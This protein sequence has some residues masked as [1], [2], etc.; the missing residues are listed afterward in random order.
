T[1]VVD[2]VSA[3]DVGKFPDSDVGESLGRI[4]GVT[5]GRAFGQGA[6][7][8][9]RG[10]APQMTLT[11]LN[12]QNVASTGWYD[13]QAIDR[14]FNYS[15]LPSQ[16]VGGMEVYK[17]SQADLNEGG[18]G[19]IVIVKTRKP[20]DMEANSVHVGLK[21]RSG[22]ISDDVSP[23]ISGLYS[24]KNDEE[25]F[26]IL[27]AG[28]AENFD[29]VRRGTEADYR[30]SEDVSPTTFI[31]ERERTALDVTAQWAPTEQLKIGLHALSLDLKANNTNTSTYIFTGMD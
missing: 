12:G 13:Q 4:P 7:V 23:E 14:S 5:V 25:T 2:A 15:L 18:I 6:S 3:E 9:I 8:S 10:A 11:Q 17:S 31:Q 30:W 19:G 20:L 24:W 29:Y 1:A 28:A 26:G 22:T 27:V 16:L 21:A